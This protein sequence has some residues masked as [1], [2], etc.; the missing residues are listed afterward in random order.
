LSLGT[1]TFSGVAPS[2]RMVLL[3]LPNPATIS[4]HVPL[5][6]IIFAEIAE[7][8][9]SLVPTAKGQEPFHG[10]AHLQAYRFWHATCLAEM[11]E[12][13]AAKRSVH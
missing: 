3:G 9:L 2:T 8:A 12:V 7:Y 10:L 1:S 6:P 5:Q 13:N 4:F 11:G